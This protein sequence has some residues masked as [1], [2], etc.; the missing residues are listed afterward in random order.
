MGLLVVFHD[1]DETQTN[2][3]IIC[4]GILD[5]CNLGCVGLCGILMKNDDR[6]GEDVG[7]VF[8]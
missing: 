1:I 5:Q 3:D 7:A 2:L 4:L 8:V 6:N